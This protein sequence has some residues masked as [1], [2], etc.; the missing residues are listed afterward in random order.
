[1]RKKKEAVE[2]KAFNTKKKLNM[3]QVITSTATAIMKEAEK[4]F[5]A[6]IP[7]IAMFGAMGAAQLAVISGMTYQGG[8]S[9]ATAAASPSA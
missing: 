5:P 7:G 9:S 4:G 6:A 2:R 3:A 8:G 1:M